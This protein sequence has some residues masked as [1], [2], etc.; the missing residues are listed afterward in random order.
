VNRSTPARR[1]RRKEGRQGSGAPVGRATEEIPR[2][3]AGAPA[4]RPRFRRLILSLILVATTFVVY[5]PALHGAFLFDDD[6]LLTSSAIVKAAD[7]LRR[8]W[9]TTQPLDYWPLTNS[10][11]WLEWRLWGL[12]PTGYHVTNVVLH[13][14]SAFLL[15]A[16]LCRLSIPGGWLAAMI[17][18][19]HPV[20]VQS[21]AWI[22]QR[23]NAL[24]MLFFL[25]SIYW[26][27][28]IVEGAGDDAARDGPEAVATDRL[29]RL[30]AYWLSLAAFVLAMLSKGSVAIL[31]GA[32]LL[33]IWWRRGRVRVRDL[34]EAAPFFAV[35][36][37]FT[38]VNMW[39]Q[40]RMPGGARDATMLERILGAAGVV[41]FYLGK[42]LAPTGLMFVYPQ[43]EIRAD[44]LRW[45]APAL[46]AAIATALLVWQRRR[47]VARALLFAW[48][49]FCLAL[50]PVMG[51]TD[52]Y[53]MKYSLVADHY[54]YVA[55]AGVAAAVAA[56]LVR[57]L[58]RFESIM[59][60]RI[61]LAASWRAALVLPLAVVAWSHAHLFAS[62]ETFYR[63]GVAS[64]PAAWVLQN[65]LGALLIEQSKNEEAADH[66]REALRLQP[67]LVQAHN[68]LCDAAAHL[69]RTDEALV[70]C[71]RAVRDSPNRASAH[72]S[73]GMAL[74]SAGRLAE[75]RREFETALRLNP[76]SVEAHYNLA[77]VL[78]EAGEP[79][80]AVDHY[81]AV[82]RAW[83]EAV[84]ARSGLGRAL[85][86]LGA[87]ADAEAAFRDAI[88]LD[89][90]AAE[91]HRNL[92]ELLLERGRFEEAVAEYRQA[93]AHE[94]P[95]P[96][97]RNN[98]GVALARLGRLAEAE[99]QFRAALALDPT[100][101]DARANLAKIGRGLP[102]RRGP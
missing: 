12:N 88:R 79:A 11:F 72:D 76:D 14:G 83:P 97:T 75:A 18:A 50:I 21:V 13:V 27:L 80:T 42:A 47:P 28:K 62:A 101:E 66:L 10:S 90:S 55:L 96:E 78:R 46:A 59:R 81:R 15:W 29:A 53:F 56:G 69:R 98:L 49:F 73:L 70:E 95:L 84:G 25:L 8:I 93:I 40:A 67:D 26:Y 63:T 20:S 6:S 52:V 9:F 44:E 4:R 33:L 2:A 74:A 3:E 91:P 37:V 7:G 43:W 54:E 24:S 34:V 64:N 38:L 94:A 58:E 60:P 48:A 99:E 30:R 87:A 1:R 71:S 5:G 85:E 51:F 35:A 22:A 92:A 41:W 17:F 77:D 39:F 23:K 31:P 19:L 89:P 86:A 45:W 102:A 36:V 100:L 82:I 57:G 61:V 16:I 65:N 32:L 68:N